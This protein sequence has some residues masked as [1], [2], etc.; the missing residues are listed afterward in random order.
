M[1]FL[2]REKQLKIKL[3]HLYPL[4]FGYSQMLVQLTLPSLDG[5]HGFNNRGALG[6]A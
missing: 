1:L 6:A 4:L 2:N 5:L 3:S